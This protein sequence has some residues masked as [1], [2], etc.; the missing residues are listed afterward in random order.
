MR[1]SDCFKKRLLKKGKP[2]LL[3]ASKAL[4]MSKHKRGR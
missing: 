1:A 2:D 3:K 4:E